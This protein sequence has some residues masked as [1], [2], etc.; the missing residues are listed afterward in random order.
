MA[1]SVLRLQMGGEIVLKKIGI[2][3]DP[4]PVGA[5]VSRRSSPR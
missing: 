1:N 5:A 2:D 4:D 3:P